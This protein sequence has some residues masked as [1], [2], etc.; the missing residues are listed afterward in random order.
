MSPPPLRRHA[1]GFLLLLSLLGARSVLAAA[2]APSIEVRPTSARPG[3]ILL[4]LIRGAVQAPKGMA[5]ERPLQF[6]LSGEHYEALSALPLDAEPGTLNVT[7]KV[8]SEELSAAVEL[9]PGNFPKRELTVAD[10]FVAP[11]ASVKSRIAADAHAFAKA[12]RTPF[13]P[14]A[15]SEG[16]ARPLDSE[17]VNAHFGD[18]RVLNGRKKTVHYGLDLDG[19]VGD[20]ISA[21][22][23]GKVVLVRDCYTTGNT[24]LI[25]HGGGV[26]T[27]YFHMSAFKVKR[28]VVVKRGELIGLVGKTGRVTGPHLHFLAHVDKL[29]VNPEALLAL[30]FP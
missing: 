25:S 10:K 12:F 6:Y 11:P 21:A 13:G 20:H 22:N 16:F 24:I 30:T 23:D 9:Q 5:G 7:V 27:G 18:Q 14:R 15:F 4:V 26:F 3:D 29:S 8:G 1:I 17:V 19:E 28:G 2:E